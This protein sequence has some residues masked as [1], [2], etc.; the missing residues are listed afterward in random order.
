SCLFL[1]S[2]KICVSSSPFSNFPHL[3][4]LVF[5]SIYA[6]NPKLCHASTHFHLLIARFLPHSLL[7]VL[8]PLPIVLLILGFFLWLALIP[9]PTFPFPSPLFPPSFLFLKKA[10]KLTYLAFLLFQSL[11]FFYINRNLLSSSNL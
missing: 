10:E 3:F 8:L 1:F 7:T 9:L 4:A 11:I 5:A 6:S 2:H